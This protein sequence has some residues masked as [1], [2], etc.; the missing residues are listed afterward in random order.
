MST[1]KFKRGIPSKGASYFFLRLVPTFLSYN[2]N[3]ILF[4]NQPSLGSNNENFLA[5]THFII[6]ANEIDSLKKM[7]EM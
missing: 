7:I 6:L 1:S 4:M 5:F 2:E 3:I